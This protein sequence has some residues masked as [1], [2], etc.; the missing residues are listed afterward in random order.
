MIDKNAAKIHQ[1]SKQK[2]IS[3][4]VSNRCKIVYGNDKSKDFINGKLIS[5]NIIRAEM[6]R[7][8]NL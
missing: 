8:I 5:E 3:Q 4:K 7:F 1:T 2:E 6:L